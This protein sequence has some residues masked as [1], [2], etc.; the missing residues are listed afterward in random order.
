M[1]QETAWNIFSQNKLELIFIY[2]TANFIYRPNFLQE[3]K[4]LGYWNYDVK[5]ENVNNSMP[6]ETWTKMRPILDRFFLPFL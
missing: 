6:H 2:V 5:R 4:C 1:K 3:K